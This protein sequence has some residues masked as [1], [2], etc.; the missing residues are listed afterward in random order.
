MYTLGEGLHLKTQN[1]LSLSNFEWYNL[2]PPVSRYIVHSWSVSV[3]ACYL[4]LISV[5]ACY[6]QLLS[7]SACYLQPLSVTA[8]YL[9]LLSVTAW[10]LNLPFVTACYLQLPSVTVYC[11]LAAVSLCDTFMQTWIMNFWCKKSLWGEGVRKLYLEVPKWTHCLFP[12][13]CVLI[14]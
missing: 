12:F 6:L 2:F 9:Q 1:K 5:T 7:V 14:K 8:C 3:T 4:Q 10:Y 13:S 11:Y